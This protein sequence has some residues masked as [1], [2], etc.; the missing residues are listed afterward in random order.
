[1]CKDSVENAYVV[2]GVTSWGVGCA[3]AKRP[4]IYTSTWPYLNWIASKIG[5]S[6]LKPIQ[7]GPSRPST[8]SDAT[9]PPPSTSSSLVRPPIRPPLLG[10]MDRWLL[11][12]VAFLR[13]S[14]AQSQFGGQAKT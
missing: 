8:P 10:P 2:V 7:I 1:M 13:V 9:K 5:Y 6:A 3:R 4:G 12:S 14:P 11:F